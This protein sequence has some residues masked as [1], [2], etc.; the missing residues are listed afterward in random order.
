M[1]LMNS[2]LDTSPTSFDVVENIL[3]GRATITND[4]LLQDLHNL[5]GVTELVIPEGIRSIE[6]SFETTQ[7]RKVVLPK[8]LECIQPEAFKSATNLEEVVFPAGIKIEILRY[9]TFDECHNL[10][11]LDLS[12]TKIRTIGTRCFA[13][14]GLEEIIPPKAL[15]CIGKYAF[16]ACESL[17]K[18]VF[19]GRR[20]KTIQYCTFHGCTRLEE[21]E[22]PDTVTRVDN[23]AFSDCWKL[24]RVVIPGCRSIN[25]YSF[26]GASDIEELVL[27][28]TYSYTDTS[29]DDPVRQKFLGECK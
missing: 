22:L 24:R 25:A 29:F 2:L 4:I 11:K 17:R 28:H 6:C 10:H 15:S 7:V 8:S 18:V 14:S 13:E 26:S 9:S 5:V 23:F 12:N 3:A 21:I 16:M 1:C 27:P 19:R 20:L